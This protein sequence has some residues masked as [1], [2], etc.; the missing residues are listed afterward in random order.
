MM[1]GLKGCDALCLVCTSFAL[2]VLVLQLK[3]MPLLGAKGFCI[4]TQ[5]VLCLGS[6]FHASVWC[7]SKQR[8]R[9]QGPLRHLGIQSFFGGCYSGKHQDGRSADLLAMEFMQAFRIV[10]V[11]SSSE[12]SLRPPK[13]TGLVHDPHDHV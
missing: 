2:R 10:Y 7:D 1:E 13:C 4:E 6:S 11:G 9:G 3:G 8:W 12:E 5:H